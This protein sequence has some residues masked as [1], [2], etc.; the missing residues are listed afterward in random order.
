MNKTDALCVS[1]QFSSFSSYCFFNTQ[2]NYKSSAFSSSTGLPQCH[3]PDFPWRGTV[4]TI[5][6]KAWE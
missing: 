1:S 6:N 4:D 3:L 5:Q 2:I